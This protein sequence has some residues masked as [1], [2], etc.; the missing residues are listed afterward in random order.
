MR[1]GY[2]IET[3]PRKAS[4]SQSIRPSYAIGSQYQ[5]SIDDYYELNRERPTEVAC[6]VLSRESRG[7]EGLER[8]ERLFVEQ[9][10][11]SESREIQTDSDPAYELE[12]AYDSSPGSGTSNDS[13]SISNSAPAPPSA[14]PSGSDSASASIPVSNSVSREQILA[15]LVE[16]VG[17]Y[18]ALLAR[19]NRLIGSKLYEDAL[20]LEQTAVRKLLI[21]H[22][23][24]CHPDATFPDSA[25]QIE[26][27]V[28]FFAGHFEASNV[29]S[30]E[31]LHSLVG[32]TASSGAEEISRDTI[33]SH[34]EQNLEALLGFLHTLRRELESNNGGER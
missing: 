31:V 15:S 23:A 6:D 7:P 11:S 24:Q 29:I 22:Y 32:L 25:T 26:R 14:P 33:R 16:N 21:N 12:P 27:A 19:I 28:A 17:Q 5:S 34:L 2:I 18:F 10:N 4:G 20:F 1:H 3:H 13:G 30:E 9:G 8:F